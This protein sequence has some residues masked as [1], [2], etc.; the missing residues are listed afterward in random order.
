MTLLFDE[1]Y[2]S[3]EFFKNK[4]VGD[5]LDRA[6]VFV[7]VGT[8]L[9]VGITSAA[10]HTVATWNAEA[11]AMNVEPQHRRIPCESG[12]PTTLHDIT[13]PCEHTLPLLASLCGATRGAGLASA[14][15]YDACTLQ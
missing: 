5:W 2:S 1:M 15:M 8:S 6:E 10:L 14:L 13:G 4:V 12:V 7:F 3:H 9:S 11:Y